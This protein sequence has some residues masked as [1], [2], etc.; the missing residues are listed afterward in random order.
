MLGLRLG[1]KLE[2][3]AIALMGTTVITALFGLVFWAV[4]ARYP[5]AE[6]GRASA[7]ISTAMMLSILS[8]MSVGLLFARFLGSTGA[9]SRPMVLLGYALGAA[10]AAVLSIGFVLFIP[11][12]DLFTSWVDRATFPLL[13]ITL[14]LFT[15]Q[16]W[17]LV[18]L[19]AAKWVPLEQ[20]LFSA[21]KLGLLMLLSLTLVSSGIVVAWAVPAAV[22]VL[23]VS[24]VL[25][26]KVLPNR[27]PPSESATQIPGRKGLSV[28]LLGEYASG[29]TTVT[30]PLVLPLI[31]VAQLGTQA[32]A[33]YAL[34]WLISD[35]FNLLLW[36]IY[37]S[38]MAEA[39]ND[40]RSSY[41][42]TR[43]TIRM[44]WLVGGLGTPFLLVAAPFLLSLLGGEYSEEGTTLLRILAIGLPF[45]I[46]YSTFISMSRVRQLMGRVVF[47][48]VLSAVL[49]IGSA[50]VLVGPFGINGVGLA[51]LGARVVTT[52]IVLIPLRR[53]LKEDRPEEKPL[54]Q[55]E[56]TP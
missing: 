25:F 56:A 48:Q 17:V 54:V 9:R 22:A 1:D 8:S 51:Y 2:L 20:L 47:L 42:L 19:R 44:V 52:L 35:A 5:A 12:D 55:Q 4:A 16:D 15:L 18:G 3:N 30:V 32:N 41:T 50:A 24:G 7:V 29:V 21:G 39:S 37:T 13:A 27:P 23:V 11:N 38:Y 28:I 36:N 31:I 43:R 49:T 46:T 14:A 45:T 6:V 53:M 34:A 33:Y 10:G 40:R 26:L